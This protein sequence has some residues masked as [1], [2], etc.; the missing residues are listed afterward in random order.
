M[1]SDNRSRIWPDGYSRRSL[2]FITNISPFNISI[3]RI[4]LDQILH[5][6]SYFWVFYILIKDYG[7]DP[8]FRS[9]A[10]LSVVPPPLPVN[11]AACEGLAG[12]SGKFPEFLRLLSKNSRNFG[13]HPDLKILGIF[14][15]TRIEV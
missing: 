5:S 10:A 12:G 15:I 9:A 7:L 11:L 13:N 8:Y 14:G 2:F 6:F 4:Q 1:Y 3:D